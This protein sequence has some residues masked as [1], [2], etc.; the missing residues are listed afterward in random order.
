MLN[1]TNLKVWSRLG[2][3]ATFG[4]VALELGNKFDNLMEESIEVNNNEHT[5]NHG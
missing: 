1:K 4:L 2:M 3:R 5:D